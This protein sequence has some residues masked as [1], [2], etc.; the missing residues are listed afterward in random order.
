MTKSLSFRATCLSIL[1]YSS[2]VP[3]GDAAEL[4]AGPSAAVPSDGKAPGDY[5]NFTVTAANWIMDA[6]AVPDING[7]LRDEVKMNLAGQ[8]PLPWSLTEF[9]QGRYAPRINVADPQAAAA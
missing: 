3:F 1:L 4:P 9:G 5:P 8:G 6:S 2:A 7:G